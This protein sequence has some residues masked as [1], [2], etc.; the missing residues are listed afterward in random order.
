MSKSNIQKKS[1]VSVVI[2]TYNHAHFL[3]RALQSVLDQTYPHW[4]VLVVDNHSQ[5]STEDV[6]KGFNDTRLRL[7]K[8]HNHGV[9]AASRNLGMREAKGEWIAFLDSDDCWYP[10]KLEILMEALKADDI[11]DV[12]SNDELMVDIKTGARR[13]LC[14][15]PWRSDFYRVLLVDGNRLSP[16]ATMVR[17]DF[18]IKHDLVFDEAQDFVTV[19]DYGFWL[20]LA[21]TG[22]RFKFVPEVQGEYVVHDTNSSARLSRHLNNCE[23]LLRHHVYNIQRLDSSPDRLWKRVVPRLRLALI[24]KHI[25]D[26]Q[27]AMAFK[28]I[29]RTWM[30][31]PVGTALCLFSKLQYRIRKINL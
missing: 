27:W 10:K 7:L 24:R 14:Y 12:L 2:P 1:L 21:R 3:G 11:Y 26:G 25:A 30:N 9:I 23:A 13:V 20:D 15:G 31:A 19:E 29:L 4:E 6:I 28:V 8:I 22:A 5:D 16:S 18:L 17:R